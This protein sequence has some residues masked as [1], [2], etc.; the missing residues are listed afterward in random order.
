MLLAAHGD[1][2]AMINT[3]PILSQVQKAECAIR[4]IAQI[5]MDAAELRTARANLEVFIEQE[6]A[7]QCQ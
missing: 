6:K 1:R 3:E 2:V 4:W 5:N 7:K